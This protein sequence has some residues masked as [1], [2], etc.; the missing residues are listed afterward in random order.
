[1]DTMTDLEVAAD[2][3]HTVG[4]LAG[5][6]AFY[7]KILSRRYLLLKLDL[8][9]ADAV[10]LDHEVVAGRTRAK[11][12]KGEIFLLPYILPQPTASNNQSFVDF[13]RSRS[14]SYEPI[15]QHHRRRTYSRSPER[16][17]NGHGSP[18]RD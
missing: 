17:S 2:V 14:R 4:V 3:V 11:S 6:F 5:N 13:R 7:F 18:D 10:A 1:M 16:P 12:M 8:L 15:P 9:L